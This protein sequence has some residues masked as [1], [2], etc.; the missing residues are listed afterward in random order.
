[1]SLYD[2]IIEILDMLRSGSKDFKTM[3]EKLTGEGLSQGEAE[4]LLD[5][6]TKQV[7]DE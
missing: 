5:R 2:K 1:M 7:E 3:L 6:L 4:D